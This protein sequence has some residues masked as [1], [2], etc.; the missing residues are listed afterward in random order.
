MCLSVRQGSG[1]MMLG[2]DVHDVA[3]E[4]STRFIER[5]LGLQ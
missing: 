4:L 5:F 1:I 3:R 2:P